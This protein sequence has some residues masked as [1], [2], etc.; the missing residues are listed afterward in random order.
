MVLMALNVERRVKVFE[1]KELRT[2]LI[3]KKDEITG[4][5]IC[6]EE[7]YFS[8]RVVRVN[9]GSLDLK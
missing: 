9:L 8:S 1:N 3:I 2:E 5:E 4:T 7:L 6:D